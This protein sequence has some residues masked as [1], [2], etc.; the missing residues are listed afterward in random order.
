MDGFTLREQAD[1]YLVG[2]STIQELND[3]VSEII[4]SEMRYG[5]RNDEDSRLAATLF[6][7]FCDGEVVQNR[8]GYFD[9]EDFRTELAA[10]LYLNE[11]TASRKESAPAK[12]S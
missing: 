9:E 2:K 4:I 12:V 5:E 11:L 7:L 1:R 3:C 6:S 10:H 8:H